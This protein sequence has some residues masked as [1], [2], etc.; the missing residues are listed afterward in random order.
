MPIGA[1]L[2]SSLYISVLTETINSESDKIQQWSVDGVPPIA[3]RFFENSAKSV[4]QGFGQEL[5]VDAVALVPASVDLGPLTTG[6]DT[7]TRQQ[8]QIVNKQGVRSTWSVV[9]VSDMGGMGRL[10]RIELQKWV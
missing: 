8:V 6:N 4:Q 5:Q 10:K 2:Q 7:G 1:M 9:R 3:C